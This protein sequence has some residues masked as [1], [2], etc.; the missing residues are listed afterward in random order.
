MG[1][2]YELEVRSSVAAFA[3]LMEQKLRANDHKG[4]WKHARMELLINR[5]D[6]EAFELRHEL[7]ACC[8]KCGHEM[9]K[10]RPGARVGLE[11]AD[12]ANFAMMIADNAGHLPYGALPDPIERGPGEGSP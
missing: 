3:L 4:G 5:V 10:G 11:A 12:V 6:A 8:T 9:G 2:R 1:R 7:G